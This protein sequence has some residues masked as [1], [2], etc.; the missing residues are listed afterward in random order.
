MLDTF[1]KYTIELIENCILLLALYF[2]V[3]CIL[4][5]FFAKHLLT[6]KTQGSVSERLE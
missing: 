3:Y 6:A 5:A 4:K 2:G 1:P